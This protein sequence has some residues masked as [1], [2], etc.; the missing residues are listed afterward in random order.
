MSKEPE[1]PPAFPFAENGREFGNY[2]GMTLRD[3]FA[4][5][6]LNGLLSNPQ[7]AKDMVAHK[8]HPEENWAWHAE[9][10]FKFANA[11]LKAREL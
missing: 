2:H 10:A 5:A 6:A 4:A 8:I 11:M 1:N 3:Y 9:T 7:I